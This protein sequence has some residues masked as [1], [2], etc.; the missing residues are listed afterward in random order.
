MNNE[1]T[2]RKA[3][4]GDIPYIIK[5]Q[6]VGHL[7]LTDGRPFVRD[8]FAGYIKKGVL[9]VAEKSGA[10]IGFI[11]G[12][13]LLNGGSICQLACVD[14][15]YRDGGV[16]RKLLIEFQKILKEN[17]VLWILTYAVKRD[18]VLHRY[19]GASVSKCDYKEVFYILK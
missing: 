4:V 9:L 16:A 19:M 18:G 5:L 17:K 8:E 1:I 15:P 12:E 11:M 14:K 3:R 6:A 2:I 10:V 13:F 7:C